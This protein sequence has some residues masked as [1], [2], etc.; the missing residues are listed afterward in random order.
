MV[1][2]QGE[3]RVTGQTEFVHGPAQ[4]PGPGA[5]M[6]VMTG[7]AQDPVLF[8]Q[9]QRCRRIGHH[10][11]PVAPDGR[12]MLWGEVPT[13]KDVLWWGA[14]DL[15]ELAPQGGQIRM[16]AHTEQVAFVEQVGAGQDLGG[17]EAPRRFEQAASTALMRPVAHVTG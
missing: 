12:R 9:D 13:Q 1:R 6:G 7:H 5:A 4:E 10:L 14:L 8:V 16:A 17:G 2:V 11:R 3:A 15:R